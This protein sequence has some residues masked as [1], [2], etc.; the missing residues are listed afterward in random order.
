MIKVD[1]MIPLFE[2]I[3]EKASKDSAADKGGRELLKIVVKA[4]LAINKIEDV[5]SIS[6]KWCEFIEKLRKSPITLDLFASLEN[7]TIDA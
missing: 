4:S 7:E 1:E 5:R 3:I 2:K 6:R